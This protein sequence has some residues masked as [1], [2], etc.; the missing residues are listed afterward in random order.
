M[1]ILFPMGNYLAILF[2]VI[3]FPLTLLNGPIQHPFHTYGDVY[4]ESGQRLDI[5]MTNGPVLIGN[6]HVS[7][8]GELVVDGFIMVSGDITLEEGA[9]VSGSNAWQLNP[10]WRW[11][12]RYVMGGWYWPW[13][14]EWGYRR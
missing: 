11:T 5:A 14:Y 9:I 8:G 13:A 3:T 4:V 1:L 6:V 7:D 10:V 12:V 2:A